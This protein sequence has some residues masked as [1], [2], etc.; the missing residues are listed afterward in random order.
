MKNYGFYAVTMQACLR[1]FIRMIAVPKTEVLEQPHL[2]G[3]G[4]SF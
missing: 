2:I 1:F 4:T 3:P